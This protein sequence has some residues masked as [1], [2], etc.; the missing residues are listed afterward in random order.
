[1]EIKLKTMKAEWVPFSVWY[2]YRKDSPLKPAGLV[3]PV[4]LV[5]VLEIKL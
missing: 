3:G 5:N 4:R 1:M 2:Y